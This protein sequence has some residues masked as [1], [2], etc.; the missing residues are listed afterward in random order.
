MASAA[1]P[2]CS[3][4]TV[5]RAPR[6]AMVTS[7]ADSI[8]RRFSSSAPHRRARR[9]LSTGSSLTSTALLAIQQLASQRVGHD[10]AD[11]HLHEAADE[12]RVAREVHDAVVGGASRQLEVSSL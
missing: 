2:A 4:F 12:P 5:K 3:P 1:R 8:C 10:L 6:R 9:W 7:S 11:A